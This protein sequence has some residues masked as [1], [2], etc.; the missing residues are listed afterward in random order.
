MKVMKY[1]AC[2]ILFFAGPV[3]AAVDLVKVDKSERRMYLLYQGE[4]VKSY[5]IAL[6]GNPKGHKR[7]EG[8]NR[9]PEGTYILDYKKEDSSYYRSMHINYPNE[10]DIANAEAR[11]VSPG[12][13]IMVHGQPNGLGWLAARTQ[14]RDWTEGCIALSNPEMDEFMALVG[15]GTP[16]HIEW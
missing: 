2:L 13:L 7:Q 10:V 8:D 15:V 1:L 11:G 6:G 9:T 3:F 5:R 12:N 16:I 14:R 4:V